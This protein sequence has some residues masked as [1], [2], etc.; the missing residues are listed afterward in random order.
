VFEIT[1]DNG[2]LACEYKRIDIEKVKKDSS[3]YRMY[4]YRKGTSGRAGDVTITTK[5]SDT[6]K[7]ENIRDLQ[8][9]KFN[10]R[11]DNTSLK[12]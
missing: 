5:I 12:F 3:S 7:L 2:E 8:F 10:D 1:H 11:N 4:A 6:K 9:L